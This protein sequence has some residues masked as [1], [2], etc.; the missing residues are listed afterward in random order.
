MDTKHCRCGHGVEHHDAPILADDGRVLVPHDPRCT[1]EED[2]V[3][4]PCSMLVV[5]PKWSHYEL[6]VPPRFAQDHVSRSLPTGKLLKQNR[7]AWT[8]RVNDEELEEWRSDADLYSDCADPYF[9]GPEAHSLQRSARKTV[10]RC[11]ELL[12]TA[13]WFRKATATKTTAP[14]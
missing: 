3:V 6:R 13:S 8:F 12:G 10:E 5:G 9:M 11:D 7:Q 2:G 1:V 14:L 4:C